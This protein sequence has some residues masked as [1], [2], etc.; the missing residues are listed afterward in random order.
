MFAWRVAAYD[1]TG[2]DL[3]KQWDCYPRGPRAVV[4]AGA[5]LAALLDG[6]NG[7]TYPAL[8]HFTRA[9]AFTFSLWLQT[10][11][12]APRLT[13]LHHSRAWMDAGSRGYELLLENALPVRQRFELIAAPLF[14][15]IGITNIAAAIAAHPDL[16]LLG[17]SHEAFEH[18]KARAILAD[19]GRGL[20]GKHL[21]IGASLDELANPKATRVARR[22]ARG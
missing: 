3:S 5:G 20:V 1:A 6:E 11:S 18:A 15:G 4:A 7:F 22:L 14:S 2:G 16:R 21:L 13:V 12:H 19:H 8:G 9:D 10:G 17:V